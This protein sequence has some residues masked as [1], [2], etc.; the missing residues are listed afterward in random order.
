MNFLLILFITI[1]AILIYNYLGHR[2][3]TATYI[4]AGKKWDNIVKELSRRK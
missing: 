1:L 2:Y 4:K 3:K